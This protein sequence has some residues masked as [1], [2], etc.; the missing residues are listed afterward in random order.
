ML[1]RAR[2]PNTHSERG[3]VRSL[4]ARRSRVIVALCSFTVALAL[5]A[6]AT[7]AGAVVAKIGGHGYGITPINGAAQANLV[8]A[9]EAQ[10]AAGLSA[11]PL[12]QR[13]DVAP[14]GGTQLV[15]LEDGPVMHSV[16]THVIYWDPNNEFTST[17]KGI[18][19]GF[20]GNVA[21]DSG[22]PTNV[23]AVAGQYTDPTGHAAYSSTS[24][25]PQ[26]DSEEYPAGECTAPNG[27]FAD[28]GPQYTECMVDQQ[29]QEELSRFITAEGLPVGPTQLYFLLL[30]H[31]VATCFE[32]PPSRFSVGENPRR[33]LVG[34][35]DP[36]RDRERG[37]VGGEPRG[38]RRPARV[39]VCVHPRLIEVVVLDVKV[40][41]VGEPMQVGRRAADVENAV[42]DLNAQES[43]TD[44]QRQAPKLSRVS[45]W[46]VSE[47]GRPAIAVEGAQRAGQATDGGRVGEQDCRRVLGG[48][49]EG[50]QTQVAH[51]RL[52]VPRGSVMERRLPRGRPAFAASQSRM[53]LR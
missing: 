38:L 8:A 39:D 49:T 27:A 44:S 40:K 32:E 2:K 16:T 5:A 24:T 26:T 4:S 48:R 45:S 50:G 46:R 33:G 14:G 19:D 25:A 1:P 6:G 42:G 53:A 17:T 30:P 15:N 37:A 41:V 9:Y 31:K 51:R 29:L 22:L 21:H 52:G 12:A 18:V 43:V 23:F 47:L 3:I 20:F 10:H 7:P 36:A 34:R 13:F 28:P 35:L 11:G